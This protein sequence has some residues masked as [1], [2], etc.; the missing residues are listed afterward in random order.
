MS[1]YCKCKKWKVLSNG[2][3][4]TVEA[5]VCIIKPEGVLFFV[6]TSNNAPLSERGELD[7]VKA[8][9]SWSTVE[10]IW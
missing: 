4:F 2:K 3:S 1:S 5:D 7:L 8:I 10:R 9:S 6:R